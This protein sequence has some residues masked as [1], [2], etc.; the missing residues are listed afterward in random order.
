MIKDLLQRKTILIFGVSSFVGSNL[1][2]FLKDHFRVVGTYHQ[3][4]VDMP[5]VLTVP[6]DVLDRDKVQTMIFTFKP[7]MTI[8]CV[9]LTS[10]KYNYEYPKYADALNTV[11]VFNVTEYSER[12]KAKTCLLST[13]Y[14]F[15]GDKREFL[16][17]DT[18]DPNTLYGKTKS[19]AEFFIQK[20][21]LN[22]IIFRCSHLYGR[23]INPRQRSLFEMVEEKM[24]NDK[25]MTIDNQVKEGFLDIT[26]LG[27]LIK[28]CLDK[29]ITN[30]LFQVSTKDIMTRYEFVQAYCKV[31]SQS[32]GLVTKGAWPFYQLDG[33]PGTSGG[34][35][36]KIDIYNIESF[37]GI[38]LPSI[39]ES[40]EYTYKRFGGSLLGKN[41][42]SVESGIKFI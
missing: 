41:K 28:M 34:L 11:G 29:D 36:Y 42:D 27:M 17:S 32:S 37:L 23:S 16:E 8:Y 35:E 6:C 19:A 33:T 10:L 31:F 39:N 22:Y 4:K 14:V 30:R 21:C 40:L 2:D 7:D 3:N 13:A 15:N 5:G 18:P 9:G 38:E 25:Q 26:Y 12:Y 20:S 24:V 1:A